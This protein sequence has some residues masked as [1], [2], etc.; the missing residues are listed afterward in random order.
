MIWKGIKVSLVGLAVIIALA[1]GTLGCS[2]DI[3]GKPTTREA[4]AF[5]KDRVPTIRIVV[6]EAD[7]TACLQN[8]K[9]ERYVRADFWFDDELV[10]DVAVRTKGFSSLQG[11]IWQDSRR[12]SLKV[13]FNFFNAAR[14]FRGLKKLNL[15][16]GYSD[17]SLM[18]DI[19]GYELCEYLGLPTPRASFVDLWLNDTHMGLYTQVEHI[20]RVFLGQNFSCDDGHLYKPSI[21]AGFLNWT[22][23]DLEEQLASEEA[24]GDG[25]LKDELDVNLGGGKLREIME[26][27]EGAD[28]AG[29]ET[30]SPEQ[31]MEL[32]FM[33]PG[34]M[35]P[36]GGVMPSGG[37]MPPRGMMPP[38]DF[39]PGQEGNNLERMW[40]KT[41]ENSPNHPALFRLLD[42]LNNEPDETF[43]VEIEKVLDVDEALR[44]LAV[45]ALIVHLDNYIG[46]G[47]NYYL[48]EVDGKFS[49][50]PWDLN[51]AFG[52]FNYGIDRKG[53]INFYIDEPT[54]G[55]VAERPLVKRLLS[56]QPY[57]E[58]YHGYLEELL[59]GPFSVD[60]MEARIDEVADMIRPYV[61]ADEIKLFST[62]DFELSLSEDIVGGMV[63]GGGDPIGLKAFVV[64][65]G[66]SVCQQLASER[67]SKSSDGSGNGGGWFKMFQR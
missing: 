1:S 34:G 26:A 37:M 42:V 19:L 43:P 4:D 8:A 36:P 58:A 44:F 66:E 57:L 46:A 38:G 53:L 56:H 9:A 3:S 27:L 25:D 29:D 65:R 5:I 33:P 35:M 13:D 11:V 16:N 63:P 20:D 52:T 39:L 2:A 51:M 10:P 31:P 55:S 15:N 54:G 23:A 41:N 50:I 12:F 47:H 32:P 7:L 48:Y 28:K 45:S 60:I 14:S 61:E 6:K 22:E 67:P 24:A 49:L 40:L 18:R 62:A 30:A 21:P 64:E 17:P 59:S